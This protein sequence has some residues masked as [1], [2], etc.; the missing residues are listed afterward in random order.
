ML[1]CD[2]ETN[3]P[4]GIVSVEYRPQPAVGKIE[5]E[6]ELE[7][8]SKPDQLLLRFRH[9]EK[10][11]I[12]SVTINGRASQAFDARSGDVKLPAVSCKVCV[13]VGY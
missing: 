12:Q 10:K 6:V 9:P 4:A 1:R 5:A 11:P 2:P 13:S 3:S 8:R 7:L